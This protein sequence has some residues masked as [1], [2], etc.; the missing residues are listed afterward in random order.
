MV[1][2]EEVFNLKPL[3]KVHLIDQLLLSLDLPNNE[4]DKIWMEEAE[5]RIGAYEAGKTQATNVYKVLAK[6]N[7]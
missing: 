5:K 2:Y 6:Y 1:A 4:L 7:K 3:E